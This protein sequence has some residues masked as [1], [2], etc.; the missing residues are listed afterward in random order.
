MSSQRSIV[1][2][3]AALLLAM[4]IIALAQDADSEESAAEIQRQINEHNAQIAE[5]NKEIEQYEVQLD[6]TSAKKQTLQ[7]TVNQLN[8]SI[9]KLAASINVTKN[10]ISATQLQIQQL[11]KGIAT[12]QTSIDVGQAGIAE[13]IRRLNEQEIESFAVRLLGAD[14][15][16]DAWQDIDAIQSL[17]T[18]IGDQIDILGQEKQSLTNTKTATEEKRRELLKQQNALLVQQGSLNATKRA[19]SDLLA[20]TKNQE[21]AYQALIAQKKAQEASFEQA[22]GDLQAKLQVAV[23]LSEVAPAG[24]GVF[25]W[26][27]DSVR[28]T[29]NFGNTAFAQSGAYNGKGHNGID[30]GGQ[31]GMPVKAALTGTVLGTGNTD[32]VRGCYS[33]GKWVMIKHGNGLSTLYAHLSQIIVSQGQSV[34]TGQVIGYSGATG[35]ATGPHLHFGVYVTSATQIIKLSEATNKKTSCSNA[36]MPVAPLSGYLNP[37]NYL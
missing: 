21:A 15:I 24:K 35:Y 18:S 28:V 23:N 29:Q 7:N 9:K 16:S 8:L 22:L 26:P 30:L 27:L 32:S 37:L 2:A 20:Q 25:H 36:V 31:I 34:A 5:L 10:Q 13:S 12:K 17:Q 14:D 11:S 33:Y 6:A 3:L 4:P 19:Q 1:I